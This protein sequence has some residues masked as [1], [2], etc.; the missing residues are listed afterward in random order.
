MPGR[1]VLKC[2]V[3]RWIQWSRKG[4]IN[5]QFSS[6]VKHIKEFRPDNLP[7]QEAQLRMAPDIRREEIR[8]MGSGNA[9]V[10]SG[11]VILVYPGEDQK[12]Y[13]VFIRRPVY[14]GVHSGQVAFPGGRYEESDANI[15]ETALREA[16]EEI[17]VDISL[18]EVAGHLTDL[19]I[20]PSNYIVTPVVGIMHQKPFFTPD[21]KEVDHIIEIPLHVL[22]D[23][24]YVDMMPVTM[25]GGACIN[26]PCYLVDSHTI[27][28]ATAMILAEF[29][30]V[31]ARILR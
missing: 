31:V 14:K 17:G 27:W 9:P 29:Q 7:G 19:Y 5:V 23:D 30:E 18:V 4:T 22:F 21:K 1:D 3:R 25:A 20:P 8:T 16:Q 2:I 26:T 28:G 11:V 13:T 15:T 10:K 24:R 6:F 12:A